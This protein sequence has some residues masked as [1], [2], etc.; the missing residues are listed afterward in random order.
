MTVGLFP[1]PVEPWCREGTVTPVCTT[2]PRT[3]STSTGDTTLALPQI[4][5]SLTSCTHL[6]Q[7]PGPGEYPSMLDIVSELY[8]SDVEYR[9]VLDIV[10]EQYKSDVEYR[11][12]LDIV[13]EQYKSD[14]EYCSVL[15]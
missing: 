10:S 1:G 12:V 15:D 14:V 8:E 9:S 13:S 4:T 2:L 3:G 6:S 5:T 11:S 7:R